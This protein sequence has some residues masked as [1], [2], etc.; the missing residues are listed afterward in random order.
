MSVVKNWLAANE[1][2]SSGLYRLA[3]SN[4]RLLGGGAGAFVMVPGRTPTPD[5]SASV[6]D[7]RSGHGSSFTNH[8]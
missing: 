4:I 5:R 3:T 8:S 6:S 7:N 2:R 1:Q